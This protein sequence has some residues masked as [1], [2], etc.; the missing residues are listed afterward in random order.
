[1]P[2]A[3]TFAIAAGLRR[4]LDALLVR[5]GHARHGRR[6]GSSPSTIPTPS[7]MR[8]C[9][10]VAEPETLAAARTEARRIGSSLAWPAVA[11][12]TATVLREASELAPRRRPAGRRRPA[13]CEPAYRPCCSRSPTM[14]GSSSTPTGSSPTATVATASMTFARLV[15][16]SL[17]SGSAAMNAS[18]RRSSTGH[19]PF[20]HAAEGDGGMRN[21]MGY[22]RRWLDEPHI[23]DHVG[24][25]SGRSATSS[26]RPGFRRSSSRCG[27]SS[28][29]SSGR[30]R[31]R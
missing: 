17:A 14:S 21:F 31:A 23:G 1:L 3:L 19:S 18:G 7:P 5:T 25:R 16:V 11:E 24:A 15:V 26:L 6:P 4:R 30:S 9:G 20:L 8:V 10:Y 29:R 12:A 28:R 22:D 2:R 27:S 13:A